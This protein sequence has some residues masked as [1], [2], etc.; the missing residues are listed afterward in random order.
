M[1]L[2]E[3][4]S[5]EIRGIYNKLF[6]E[7]EIL[8]KIQLTKYYDT[9]RQR[10]GP[11]KL[12]ALDG[13][14]LLI[15]MHDHGNR[16]S[17]VYW[18]EFKND[19]EF[20]AHFG[21]IAGGSA[22]KFGI[23]KRKETG[24]W[25][26]G[27]AQA[28]TEIVIEEAIGR[29]RKHRD[30]LIAAATL[31]ENFSSNGSDEEYGKLQ[32][33][34]D[35]IAPSICDT[36]WGHKYL[37]LLYPEKLDD[38][39]NTDYQR[40]HLIML[41]QIPPSG[42]GRFVMAGRYVAIA[43]ELEIPINSLTAITNFRHGRPHRY[44]RI[45]TSDGKEP[46]NHWPEMRD[47]NYVA[48]GWTKVGDLSTV[49][50]TQDGKETIRQLLQANYS[51]TPQVMG[52]WTKQLFDFSTAIHENDIV[53]AAEGSTMLGIG[54]V[55]GGYKYDGTIEFCHMIP[56]QWLTLQEWKPPVVEGRRTTVHPMRKD[57]RNIIEIETRILH[58]SPIVATVP[59]LT[60]GT[61]KRI[62]SILE[63][64]GQVVIYGPPGTGKTY[65]AQKTARELA[66]I[67]N[68]KLP[69]HSLNDKQKSSILG[70]D[71]KATGTVRF[72]CF[73]PAYGYEDFLE[74]YRPEAS[75]GQVNFVL[76]DG[77]FKALCEDAS[78]NPQYQYYL[79]IDEINRGDIPR[80]FG[81]LMTI[82]EK[83]K[84][85]NPIILP[86]SKQSFKVPSNVYIIGTMNTAD[87]SIALLDTA[88]RRRFGFIELMPD[89]SILG[90][91]TIEGIPLGPWLSA[92]NQRVC[93]SVGRDARNLQI[94]HSYLLENG[95]PIK[96]FSKLA[97]VI[98]E[99]LIPLLQEYCYEDY[100]ALEK[101]LGE[102][103]IDRNKQQIRY[104]LFD[105]S[106]QEELVQALLAPSPEILTTPQAQVSE[107]D[108]AEEEG[109]LEDEGDNNEE[110]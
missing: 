30:D 102:G 96:D 29:A 15:T 73:H 77:I 12:R 10:F 32:E 61:E 28:Q 23:Y 74:G 34:L 47:G 106:R 80:I 37:S 84:R 90:D 109:D 8:S 59:F 86:L 43:N 55:T 9:F 83:D 17:L 70:E 100:S 72:C 108:A 97:K 103:L 33:D 63:R 65:W 92:L 48:V 3:K 6:N 46:R 58:A 88:L 22:L 41:L 82:L 75:N 45:G 50:R 104:E 11:D 105:G 94:G 40:F 64:K 49:E 13:E 87:R 68:F 81:E 31:L 21:S 38:Y 1:L 5:Q 85:G 66:A 14:E 110:Q 78:A 20:P 91:V 16:D 99:D 56:V 53:L 26:T 18:L 36:A 71:G 4:L 93:D 62:Y 98:F 69:F 51:N 60:E 42:E 7:S 79:V 39:H 24:A 67:S 35:T 19:E 44:W 27:S 89:I 25:M 2:D 54:R 101:I 52:R 76:R 107:V 95:L 57:I